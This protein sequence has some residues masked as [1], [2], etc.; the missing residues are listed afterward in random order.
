MAEMIE[1]FRSFEAGPDQAG[2][3]WQV[4]F[5][6]QQNAISIRHADAVDV[7]FEISA[8]GR[9]ERKVIALAHTDLLRLAAER[10]RPL[11]DPWA[12]RLAAAHLKKMIESGQDMDKTLVAPSYEEL[13]AYAA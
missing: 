13:A 12:A 2:R 6:W 7:K 4:R 8:A 9:R 3:T 11:T 5:M 10:N 1:N